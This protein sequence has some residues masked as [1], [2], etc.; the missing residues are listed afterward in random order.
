MVTPFLLVLC[1]VFL[2]RIAEL[3]IAKKNALYL[4]SLG[5]YEVGAGHYPL[6]VLMHAGFFLSLIA[7][8]YGRGLEAVDPALL[9]F[10]IFV[11][12]QGLRVWILRSLGRYWNTRIFVVPGSEPVVRGPYRFLRHPNYVVVALELFTL[13]LAFGAVVTAVVFTV[14]N[15]A[16]LRVRIRVEEAALCEAT[17]YAETMGPRSRFV[18][19]RKR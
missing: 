12:A 14:L 7:E 16:V 18:P 11:V 1:F 19:F 9:P 4:R 3:V 17:G 6:L 13:P 5:G 10:A 2:Q 15:F 8:V